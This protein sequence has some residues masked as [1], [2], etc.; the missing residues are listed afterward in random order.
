MNLIAQDILAY[1][2]PG[3][4]ATGQI[5]PYIYPEQCESLLFIYLV[6]WQ[7]QEAELYRPKN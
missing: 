2:L 4:V 5:V 7:R 1:F 3:G 6:Y